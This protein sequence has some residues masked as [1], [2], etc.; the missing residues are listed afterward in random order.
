[1][2]QE[3]I[4]TYKADPMNHEVGDI[5]NLIYIGIGKR[6]KEAARKAAEQNQAHKAKEPGTIESGV[7][8]EKNMKSSSIF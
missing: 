5:V 6:D 2:A 7:E 1:M 4:E 8:P 3:Q